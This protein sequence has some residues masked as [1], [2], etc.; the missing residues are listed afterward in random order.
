MHEVFATDIKQVIRIVLPYSF[1]FK[2]YSLNCSPNYSLHAHFF[3]INEKGHCYKIPKK[4]T[5][6][7]PCNV[8]VDAEY[9][10]SL[11]VK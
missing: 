7:N 10:S 6:C 2:C 5:I 1:I 11:N 9:T 8:L 4:D 3:S